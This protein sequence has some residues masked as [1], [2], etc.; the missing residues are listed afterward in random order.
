MLNYKEMNITNVQPNLFGSEEL[1]TIHEGKAVTSSLQ[2]AKYFSK[3]H[4]HVLRDIRELECSDL[5]KESNFGLSFY[6]RDLDNRG[7]HK[8]PLYYMTKDGFIFLVMGFTGQQAAKF[9]EDYINAFNKMEEYLKGQQVIEKQIY[10]LVADKLRTSAEAFNKYGKK[11]SKRFEV[12]VLLPDIVPFLWRDKDTLET[13]INNLLAS[14]HNNTAS[15]IYF[16]Y[17]SHKH[18]KENQAIRNFIQE[19][20][21]KAYEGFKIIPC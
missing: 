11:L 18:E 3:E 13:N 2:V 17:S 21:Q 9:K 20:T 12:P 14:Y 19:I 5:F 16:F 6:I 10:N 7:Q 1:I 15:S 8:Y 4:R